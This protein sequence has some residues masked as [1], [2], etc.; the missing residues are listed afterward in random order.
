MTDLFQSYQPGLESPAAHAFVVS[1]DDGADLPT[2]TRGVS[3]A[4]AGLVRVTM[5]GGET[6]EIYI[7]AGVPFPLRVVRVWATGTTATGI[8]GLC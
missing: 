3:V 4:A 1:P 8:V 6:V 2:T 7:A 5:L